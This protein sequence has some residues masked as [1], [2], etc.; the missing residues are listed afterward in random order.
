M[1]IKIPDLLQDQDQN[2]MKIIIKK[3]NIKNEK[4]SI[5]DILDQILRI[6]QDQ[7]LIK[8]T[9]KENTTEIIV[10]L[11]NQE[12]EIILLTQKILTLN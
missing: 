10:T 6:H 4:I 9:K 8:D 1:S 3:T 12:E 2:Q 7:I 5:I 11:M